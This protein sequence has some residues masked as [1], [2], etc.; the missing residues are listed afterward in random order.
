M[1]KHNNTVYLRHVVEA[2]EKINELVARGGRKLFDDDF[3]IA[4][5]IVRELI[6][7]GEA[8]RNVSAEFRDK[9]PELPWKDM[10]GMRDW[11]VHGYAEIDW[12]KVWNTAVGD[13]AGLRER[14][15]KILSAET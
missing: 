11:L 3:A 9:Y 8:V 2:V 6:V 14:V 15:E 13:L 4:D 12:N 5:A 1:S 10:V 7:V